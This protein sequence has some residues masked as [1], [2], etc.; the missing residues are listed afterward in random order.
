M[1]RARF[2]GKGLPYL[3][4]EAWPGW[5][6]VVE[7]SDGSGRTTQIALLK[8][9]LEAEGYAVLDT[10]LRRSTLVSNAIEQAKQGNLL[11]KTTLSLLYATDFADQ[12]ENKII[13]ALRAGFVVLANRYIFTMMTR[14]LARGADP[15][16]L[17]NLFGF[18]V[19]PDLT[20]YLQA[21]VETLLHRAFQKYGR[22]NYWESGM[23]IG[24]SGDMFDSFRRYQTRLRQEYDRLAR[25]YDFITL[26]AAQDVDSIQKEIRQH[27]LDLLGEGERPRGR[28]RRTQ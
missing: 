13:P 3:K 12:L 10:H 11:G 4:V 17:E 19:V 5:L 6:V 23:D 2:Y 9:W 20:I 8:E 27:V 28:Q 7:G 25:Q 21:D 26:D 24:L 1:R 22:L 16:W 14:D 15:E 18:A